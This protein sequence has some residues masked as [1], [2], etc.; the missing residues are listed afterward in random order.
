MNFEDIEELLNGDPSELLS[1]DTNENTE[2]I[3][4][5]NNIV[6]KKGEVY[7]LGDF[8]FYNFDKKPL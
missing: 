5:W 6:H 3:N 2:I 1:N 7:F 8:S 4:N